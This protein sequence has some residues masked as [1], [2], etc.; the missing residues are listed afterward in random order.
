MALIEK[1]SAIGEAIRA[2]TGKTDLLTL[3][4]MPTEIAAI[5]TGG[6]SGVHNHVI[7]TYTFTFEGTSTGFTA[8]G[9]Q[10]LDLTQFGVKEDLSNLVAVIFNCNC[11][12]WNYIIQSGVNKSKYSYLSKTYQKMIVE[13]GQLVLKSGVYSANTDYSSIYFANKEANNVRLYYKDSS[14]SST[15][16]VYFTKAYIIVEEEA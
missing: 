12:Y 6:A 11:V 9:T 1:L 8:E 10:S 2:K 7:N 13:D 14:Y 3:D 16:P 4:E 5:E 15:R